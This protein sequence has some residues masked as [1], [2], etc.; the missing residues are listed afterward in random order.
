MKVRAK[1]PVASP[2]TIKPVFMLRFALSR[3]TVGFLLDQPV[4]RHCHE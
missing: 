1:I 2:P 4:E 3:S